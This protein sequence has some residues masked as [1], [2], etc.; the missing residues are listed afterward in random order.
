METTG[1]PVDASLMRAKRQVQHC[2]H[3]N[4]NGVKTKRAKLDG[5]GCGCTVAAKHSEVGKP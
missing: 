3:S 4:E 1:I 5:R 2:M